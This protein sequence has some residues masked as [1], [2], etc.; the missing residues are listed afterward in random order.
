MKKAPAKQAAPVAKAPAKK[1]TP[2]K[3]PAG[4]RK[5]PVSALVVKAGEGAWTK[6]ELKGVLDQLHEQREHSLAMIA[7]QSSS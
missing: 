3:K 1:T 5:A 4:A 2:L 7:A 6:A